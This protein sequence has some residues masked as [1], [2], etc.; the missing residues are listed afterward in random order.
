MTAAELLH[1]LRN[2]DIR[3]CVE[4]GQLHCNGPREALTAELRAALRESKTEILTLLDRVGATAPRR[5]PPLQR[6]VRDA[7]PLLSFAQERLWFLDQFEPNTPLYNVPKAIRIRGSLNRAFL[8]Q[9]LNEI[10]HRHEVLR[11]TFFAV[12]GQAVQKISPS[13]AIRIPV[14]DLSNRPYD[15]REE[16]ALEIA[17]QEIRRPFDL[18]SGPL[19][20]AALVRLA[21]DDHLLLLTLHHIVSDGWSMEVL[22][23]ELSALYNA[24]C[25]GQPLPLAELSIQYAD[26]AQWQRQW[27]QGANLQDQIRYWKDQLENIAAVQLPTD[28][29]R[30]SIQRYVGARQAILLSGKLATGLQAL[31]QRERVTV[32]MTL[33][34]AFKTLLHRYTGQEDI[35]VATPIAGRNRVEI[36]PLIGFFV[37][38]LVL[39]SYL[40]GNPTFGELLRQVRDVALGAYSNQDLPFEKLVEEL[41]PERNL[42]HAPLAQVMFAFQNFQSAALVLSGCSIEPLDLDRETAKFDLTLQ[43]SQEASGMRCVLAYNTDLFE[44]ATIARMLDHWRILL[45][46][47]VAD[48]E[49]R[50]SDLPLLTDVERTQ[51]LV[52][53]NDT[54]K[55]YPRDKCLYEL[56]EE[57]VERTPDALAVVFSSTVSRENQTLTYRE[58]NTRANQLAHY[59]RKLGVGQES[60]VG[61]FMERSLEML[62]ALLGALKAGAAYVPLDPSHP[63]E[64]LAFMMADSGIAVVLT[65]TQFLAAVADVTSASG[66]EQ[67]GILN[68]ARNLSATVRPPTVVC[69]N[70][71]WP[72]I[73]REN[74]QNPACEVTPENLAYV[75]Y[76]SGTTGQPKG[77]MIQHRSLV[78]YLSWVKD[79]LLGDRVDSL[80]VVTN[81]SFDASLKQLWAPLLRGRAVWLL[82]NEV[83]AEPLALWDA[84]AKRKKVAIN[85]VPSLWEA[86]LQAVTGRADGAK[87]CNETITLLLGG[88]RPTQE[89]VER[90]FTVFP[91]IQIWNLYGP[92]EATANAA[93][94]RIARGDQVTIGHPIYNSQ[95]FILDGYLKPVPVGVPGQLYIGGDGLA[96]GYLNSTELTAEKFVPHPFTDE[97]GSRLYKTGDR[98]RYLPD[99]SI[100]FLGRIDHQ[101]KIRGFRIELGEIETVLKNHPAVGEAVV[102]V[103]QDSSEE[104]RLVG[105]VI[106]NSAVEVSALRRFLK[107]RLPD[108]MVPSAFVF[109]D[110]LPLTPTGKIDRRALPAPDQS[111]P[112]LASDFVAPCTPTEELV[113][114]TWADILK[115][116][117]VSIHDNFFELGGHSLLATQVISRLRDAFR[118]D[119]PLRLLFEHPTIVGLAE[120]IETLLWAGES[121]ILDDLESL[122]DHEAQELLNKSVTGLKLGNL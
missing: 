16:Q 10:V 51:L 17:N 79:G 96:R 102:V 59:L 97:P 31:A 2:L 57:Q 8:E 76:T 72:E 65:Q 115:L 80:P 39:R 28:R 121:N 75:I 74:D 26:F 14:L 53:W 21:S 38:T 86:V 112:D 1:K 78:N 63:A 61:I 4:N 90:S 66:R 122:S 30:P 106:T 3:I 49:Q 77:V 56:V 64:R 34:A 5:Q 92:T 62:V 110:C 83:I 85:C 54:K 105:Y 11:T 89:L 27:L 52:D 29:P 117:R 67:S 55:E 104:K 101:V 47:I 82:S 7:D 15:E 68:D 41:N 98:A 20:R 9:S 33:L 81:L 108:Y 12:G 37:N 40:S 93:A 70:N 69:L 42:A 18:R 36:E 43:V 94:A 114:R 107:E 111:R 48:P 13:L 44:K 91:K 46:A 19:I 23:R 118:F 71:A 58:L 109:L 73:G 22:N 103:R 113:A 88:D 45:E 100:E 25:S 32:F 87:P 84:V 95:S 99:G 119:L 120:R 60:R 50:L 116:E 6:T 24:L 35:A